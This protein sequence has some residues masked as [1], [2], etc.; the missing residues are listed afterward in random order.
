MIPRTIARP[1]PAGLVL[2]VVT[3]FPAASG[4]AASDAGPALEAEASPGYSQPWKL[5]VGLYRAGSESSL[6]L[7]LRRSVSDFNFWIGAYVEGGNG[8]VVRLGADWTF[9]SEWLRVTPTI[10]YATNGFWG[11][12]LYSEAGERAFLIAGY[13]QT[14]EKDYFN[15]TFDPNESVQLGAGLEIDKRNR[16]TA[17]SIFD[18][19]LGTGQQNT[20]VVFRR[21]TSP[22]HRLTVDVLYKSGHTDAGDFV[23]GLGVQATFDWP[24]FFV[25]AAY[26]PYANFTDGT[27]YR[28]GCGARF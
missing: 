25:R 12:Q 9:R 17:Y 3:A 24:W 26:D 7:N 1:L 10:A 6:D 5:T 14:N 16:L 23:R 2:L 15:L 22:G 19:R 8:G 11:G 4:V 28:I 27:M 20:H 13:S 18:V 21:H